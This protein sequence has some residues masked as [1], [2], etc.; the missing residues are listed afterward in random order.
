MIQYLAFALLALNPIPGAPGTGTPE[1]TAGRVAG[2]PQPQ[3]ARTFDPGPADF[4]FLQFIQGKSSVQVLAR[5]GH[6]H[7]V[8]QGSNGSEGWTYYRA[9][10]RLFWVFF[11]HGKA[12]L[13]VPSDGWHLGG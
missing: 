9:D 4:E 5:F 7:R 13:G 8:E 12:T 3:L 6:P 1:G 10:G 11:R 2:S